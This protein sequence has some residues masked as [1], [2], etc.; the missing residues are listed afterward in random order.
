MK[1]L[2][3]FSSAAALAGTVLFSCK[4]EEKIV[5]KEVTA[6]IPADVQAAADKWNN[7]EKTADPLFMKSL[8]YTDL[9][10]EQFSFSK[11]NLFQGLYTSYQELIKNPDLKSEIAKQPNAFM[12]VATSI[13]ENRSGNTRSPNYAL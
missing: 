9:G 5:T 12:E 1:K 11:G 7:L 4:Q 6:V 10:S 8:E 2:L 3:K 13:S